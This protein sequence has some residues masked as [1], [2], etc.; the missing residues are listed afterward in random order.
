VEALK[1][2]KKIEGLVVDEKSA[3][4]VKQLVAALEEETKSKMEVAAGK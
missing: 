4:L 2:A 1:K 3:K